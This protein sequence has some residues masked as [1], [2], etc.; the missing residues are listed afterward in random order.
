LALM[1]HEIRT[2]M[3]GIL[4][5]VDF[6]K[7]TKMTA[8]QQ[9]FIN[10]ISDCSK[11]LLNTLNDILDISKLEAGKLQISNVNFDLRTVINNSAR[12]MQLLAD[13]K[14]IYLRVEIADNV[15]PLVYG[16][17]HR[18]QQCV[19][20]FLNNAV[21]FTGHGGVTLRASFRDGLIPMLRI[22]VTDTGI[23]ISKENLKKLFR[24]FSQA[25]SSTSRKYGGTGLGLSIIKSLVSLMGGKIG[26]KSEEGKGSTFWFE[27]PYHEPVASA[28][29][30]EEKPV[31]EIAPLLVLLAEDNKV[32]QQIALRLLGGKG[33]RV[34]VAEN[35]QIA[36]RMVQEN[37]Y[38]QVLMDVNMPLMSG[39]EATQKIR[40]LGGRFETL[41][42]IALTASVMEEYIQQCY[43]AGMNDYV[44]KPF[45]PR[46]LYAAM[47]RH[48]T[49][50][51][52]LK[53]GQHNQPIPVAATGQPAPKKRATLNANLRAIREELGSEYMTT[54]VD[55]SAKEV[56]HLLSLIHEA[57]KQGDYA[58][59][60]RSAHDLKSVSGLVGM[61]HACHAAEELE[62]ACAKENQAAV[63]R[64][65]EVLDAEAQKELA[66]IAE[67]K[68]EE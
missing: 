6:M 51:M 52:L 60:H 33:H 64:L 62:I 9:G 43:D 2:P 8:E 42:I 38:D 22:D 4:G 18:M 67:V 54:L 65:I 28:A 55:N 46:A 41:P 68:S 45:A 20:N 44:P 29:A 56:K 16:D 19:I 24:S 17:P 63:P 48:V 32:N 31:P 23:G 34:D 49:A 11:T 57:M 7:E 10:T 53:E 27:V 25:D 13:E 39:L 50:G 35:G 3:T 26:V 66:E 61:T 14:D 1:S 40:E 5:M 12:V 15:P 58:A 30:E 37:V 36:L 47:A 21:K 59:L